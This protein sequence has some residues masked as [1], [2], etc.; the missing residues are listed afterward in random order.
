MSSEWKNGSTRRWREIREVVLTRDNRRCQL[1]LEGC[2]EVAT[3]VHH[4]R[5]KEHGDN[6]ADLVAACASCN[7]KTGRPSK[8]DPD[9]LPWQGW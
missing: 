6:P 1:G 8:H 4:T 2:T 9:P 3:H 7:L 5:G